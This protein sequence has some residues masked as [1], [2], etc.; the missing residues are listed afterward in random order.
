MTDSSTWATGHYGLILWPG[1]AVVLVSLALALIG[2]G[3]TN[4]LKPKK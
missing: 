2:D 4:I 1:F 3:L